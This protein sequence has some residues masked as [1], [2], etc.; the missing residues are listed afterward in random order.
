MKKHLLFVIESLACAGAEKSLIS[1]LSTLDYTKY[2][3]DLQLFS[4]GGEF[5]PY[6]PPEVNILPSLNYTKFAEKS[7]LNQLLTFDVKKIF[8]RW[9]YSFAIHLH[10]TSHADNARLYW[11]YVSR[12]LSANKKKY[13]V[14]VAYAQG[15]PTFYVA[16]KINAEKKLCW[17]NVG[18]ELTGINRHFQERFYSVMNHIVTVSVSSYTTFKKVYPQFADKMIVIWDM[19]DGN[20]IKRMSL[21]KTEINIDNN[22][23]CLLTI[24][25][26][27]KF[28]KGYDIS[29]EACKILKERGI[30]FKWYAIGRG[31]YQTEMEAFITENDLQKHF[32]LLGTTP[33][34]YPVIKDCTIYV[35]TS[36][37]EGYGLSIAEARILNKPVV[38]TEF[39]AV[40]S[41]MV[42][43][44]NGLVV[45]QEPVAVAD[46]VERLLTDHE[47]YDSI[48]EYL[49][50]EKKGNTD[51]IRKFYKLIET[52]S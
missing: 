22:H 39:D 38:T 28:Q 32:I 23:P 24:A 12:Y 46:A 41:Q 21:K 27:N 30:D 40:Y 11:R 10:K 5:E 52:E 6:V 1:L 36:R 37:H 49:K 9:R 4:S 31:P 17:V 16:E 51:E 26:L 25:R 29:L 19:L 44:R 15:V 50:Q 18:Y 14:A 2:E 43:G 20:L 45:K 33:N 13:D 3:V 8:A 42:Q 7:I 34:P 47:L 48:V 35:Q